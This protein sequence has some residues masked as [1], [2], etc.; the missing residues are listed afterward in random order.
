MTIMLKRNCLRRITVLTGMIAL[1][2]ACAVTTRADALDVLSTDSAWLHSCEK[3][4]KYLEVVAPS[5]KAIEMYP[6]AEGSVS[7]EPKISIYDLKLPTLPGKLSLQQLFIE[8]ESTDIVL[9]NDDGYSLMVLASPRQPITDLW[10]NQSDSS[11][12]DNDR[13][14]RTKDILGD[15]A[16]V[17][18]LMLYGLEHSSDP[19]HCK[20]DTVRKD[21]KTFAS[22]IFADHRAGVSSVYSI[23][24]EQ[25]SGYVQV[26]NT[27]KTGSGLK[28]KSI[29]ALIIGRDR[30][31]SV[32]YGAPPSDLEFAGTVL[33]ALTK[34]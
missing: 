23:Q 20:E 14:R 1:L 26:F 3:S 10:A 22:R 24:T 13:A 5:K 21:M 30:V 12:V 31:F 32:A 11:D 34:R 19:I 33:S 15:D 29:E 17:H 16:D 28:L 8:D 27:K 4:R 9:R 2:T 6:E 18:R 25:V 7:K